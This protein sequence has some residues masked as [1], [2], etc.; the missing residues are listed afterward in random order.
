M[1][2]YSVECPVA[3]DKVTSRAERVLERG[4]LWPAGCRTKG[5]RMRARNSDM[6]LYPITKTPFPD[7]AIAYSALQEKRSSVDVARRRHLVVSFCVGDSIWCRVCHGLEHGLNDPLLS[8]QVCMYVI[9]AGE[10][11][12][13]ALIG[14]CQNLA[15]N[16]RIP[17]QKLRIRLRGRAVCD[18]LAP[19]P[20]A[21]CSRHRGCGALTPEGRRCGYAAQFV[22]RT[23]FRAWPNLR[24]RGHFAKGSAIDL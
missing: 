22:D 5:T 10:S 4:R 9:G 16:H 20:C 7:A 6:A 8:Q 18:A 19:N 2:F 3:K 12:C 21:F 14:L 13:C 11:P 24:E 1:Q 17:V 15:D 23:G